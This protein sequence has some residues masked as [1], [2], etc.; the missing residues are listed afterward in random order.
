M[1]EEHLHVARLTRALAAHLLERATLTAKHLDLGVTE[2]RAVEQLYLSQPM[3]IGDLGSS[4]ALTSGSVTA[5]VKR[6]IAKDIV[7]RQADNE[8]RRRVWISINPDKI[9][10]FESF[11]LSTIAIGQQAVEDF[12]QEDRETVVRFLEHY[13]AASTRSTDNLKREFKTKKRPGHVRPGLDDNPLR[14]TSNIRT[15]SKPRR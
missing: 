10:W 6:L 2:I 14:R 3:T 4:L 9:E 13:C 5:L 8:D 7:V 15:I 12:P 11:Y 1:I